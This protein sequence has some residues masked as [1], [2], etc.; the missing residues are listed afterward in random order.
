MVV[1][2]HPQPLPHQ[3]FITIITGPALGPVQSLVEHTGLRDARPP[4]NLASNTAG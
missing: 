3:L 2:G 4:T 1:V